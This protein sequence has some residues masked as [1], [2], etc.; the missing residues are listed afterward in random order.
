ML[1]CQAGEV[2]LAQVHDIAFGVFPNKGKAL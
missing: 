1:V 2:V